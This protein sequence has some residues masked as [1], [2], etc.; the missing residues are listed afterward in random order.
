MHQVRSRHHVVGLRVAEPR[1]HR[2][3]ERM[4]L[5]A[6]L[7][8]VLMLLMRAASRQV[9]QWC[10]ALP[11][12]CTAYSCCPAGSTNVLG[13]QTQTTSTCATAILIGSSCTATCCSNLGQWHRA[14]S[15]CG[16]QTHSSRHPVCDGCA[17][18]TK[19][20]LCDQIVSCLMQQCGH[21]ETPQPSYTESNMHLHVPNARML[22]LSCTVAA[23]TFT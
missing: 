19:H 12:A 2:T 17:Q 9:E 4:T 16:A 13:P 8:S 3:Q 21:A 20:Y 15:A 10:T 11:D 6:L 14:A 22:F 18:V 23:T 5:G 7:G 1:R